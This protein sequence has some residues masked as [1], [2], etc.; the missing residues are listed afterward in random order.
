MDFARFIQHIHT[1]FS[2]CSTLYTIHRLNKV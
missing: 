1:Q 2:S